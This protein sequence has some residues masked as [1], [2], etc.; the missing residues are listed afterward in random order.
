MWKG[1][2]D[3]IDNIEVGSMKAIAQICPCKIY[4][5]ALGPIKRQKNYKFFFSKKILLGGFTLNDPS[6]FFD[7]KITTQF[8]NIISR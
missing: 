3:K 7:R 4:V 1:H 5:I 2:H 8:L 6:G